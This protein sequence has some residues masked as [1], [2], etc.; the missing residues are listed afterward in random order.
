MELSSEHVFYRNLSSSPYSHE[1]ATARLGSKGSRFIPDETRLVL[2]SLLTDSPSW[3]KDTKEVAL[4]V[5]QR[6]VEEA[7]EEAVV[8]VDLVLEPKESRIAR[9]R[10][11]IPVFH[12][13][14]YSL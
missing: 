9:K 5:P 11:S 12:L 7:P 2:V 10:A 8:A 6:E 3:E 13:N 14:L 4:E 1:E